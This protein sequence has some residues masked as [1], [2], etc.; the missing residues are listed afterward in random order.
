MWKW[1]SCF[2]HPEK[3]YVIS[4]PKENDEAAA[5]L[6]QRRFRE[7]MKVKIRVVSPCSIS[8]TGETE[9]YNSF[10]RVRL[11]CDNFNYYCFLK[12]NTI[13]KAYIKQGKL[14]IWMDRYAVRHCYDRHI[15]VDL[16]TRKI[17]W[18]EHEAKEH[19]ECV[20]SPSKLR[21]LLPGEHDTEGQ[22][23]KQ[24]SSYSYYR[25]TLSDTSVYQT[26]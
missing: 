3:K 18:I 16:K 24:L 23:L 26:S 8:G 25:Y 14:F 12:P 6:I 19:R 1:I 10:T 22:H 9:F 7:C 15:E 11:L 21:M 17:Y 20:D 2:R 13:D 5:V 4:P